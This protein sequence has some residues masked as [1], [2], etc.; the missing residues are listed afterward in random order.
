MSVTPLEEIVARALAEDLGAGDV[1]TA[2]TVPGDARARAVISQKAPGVVFG[3][4]PARLTF[5][6]LDPKAEFES[7]AAGGRVARAAARCCAVQGQAR[8]LLSGERTA[9]NFLQR[10]SGVATLAARCVR[11]IEDIQPR[12]PSFSIRARPPPACARWRRRPSRRAAR[13]TTGPGS[14]TR[15]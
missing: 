4:E 1:T 5:R 15:S 6:Q 7:L 13:P 14:T 11:A 2:A 9:L 10:L 12:P 3:L 8:A